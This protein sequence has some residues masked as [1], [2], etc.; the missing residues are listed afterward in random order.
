MVDRRFS[1]EDLS[2]EPKRQEPSIQGLKPVIG[3]ANMDVMAAAR[4]AVPKGLS[5]GKLTVAV[6]A[7]NPGMTRC[8]A[9]PQNRADARA[10]E[11]IGRLVRE[12]RLGPEASVR[13][14]NLL[15]KQVDD[16]AEEIQSEEIRSGRPISLPDAYLIACERWMLRRETAVT[17]AREKEPDLDAYFDYLGKC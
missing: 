1:P 5:T 15:Q 11:L 13:L 12:A 17:V 4:Q 8:E 10:T 7:H 9:V 3:G 2:L 14:S 6:K 16:L